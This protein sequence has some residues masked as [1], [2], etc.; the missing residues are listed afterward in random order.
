M[1]DNDTDD[2]Y[3]IVEFLPP[4]TDGNKEVDIVPSSWLTQ[5][6]EDSYSYYPDPDNYHKLDKYVQELRN[7]KNSWSKYSVQIISFAENY[8]Q[9]KRRLKR[10]FTTI[11][12]KS[13]DE[14]S[15]PIGKPLMMSEACV[16]NEMHD[17]VPM[18]DEGSSSSFI[19]K[20]KLK[21]KNIKQTNEKKLD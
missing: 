11:N 15:R 12:V 8:S 7:A 21:I 1:G 18:H 2:I 4:S 13:T 3:A 17:I 9:A 20:N 19:E 14:S 5:V 16:L 10:S 6:D